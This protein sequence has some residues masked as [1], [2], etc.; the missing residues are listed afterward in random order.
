VSTITSE[1]VRPYGSAGLHLAYLETSAWNALADDPRCD[2][3]IA[4]LQSRRVIA[5]ASVIS[6]G[7]ILRT[8]DRDRV[9]RLRSLLLRLHGDR[10][11]LE[12]PMTLASETARAFFRKETDFLLPQSGPGRSLL[13]FLRRPDDRDTPAIAAW[14]ENLE[15]AHDLFVAE[16]RPDRP[17]RDTQ[18]FSREVTGHESF[19]KLLSTL[20]AALELSLSLAQVSELTNGV[21][22]WRAVAGTLGYIITQAM[23]H[24]PKRV[25]NRKRP[26]GADMWQA[27]YLGVA[28]A[29]VSSDVRLLEAV[30]EVSSTLSYRRCVVST[31]DFLEGISMRDMEPRCSVCG[32]STQVGLH[33]FDPRVAAAS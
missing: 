33:A 5:L 20:P 7:E 3:I 24:S 23:A 21:D 17:N 28:E 1:L 15:R 16:I 25:R 18:Y 9:D 26:G 12:R 30:R 2:A 27:V 14:L 31:V 6:A 4:E 8:P 13:D 22:I 10:P 11:L 19:L 29:F 32:S